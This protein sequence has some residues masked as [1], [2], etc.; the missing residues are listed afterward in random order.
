MNL[1]ASFQISEIEGFDIVA[2]AEVVSREY[3]EEVKKRY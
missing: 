1:F 3:L 2:I